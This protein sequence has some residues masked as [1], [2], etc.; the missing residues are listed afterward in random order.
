MSRE[1]D[2]PALLAKARD[3]AAVL[4]EILDL[5]FLA[6]AGLGGNPGATPTRDPLLRPAERPISRPWPWGAGG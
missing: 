3:E 6:A 5:L 1:T 2:L 4:A